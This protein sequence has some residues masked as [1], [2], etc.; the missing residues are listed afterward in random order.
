MFGNASNCSS[1]DPNWTS[2]SYLYT[3]NNNG[4]NAEADGFTVPLV[5]MA[6]VTPC[7]TYHIKLAISDV[8]DGAFDSYVLIQALS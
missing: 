3:N 5:A 1:I 4:N 2:Y 7:S 6:E 8:Y